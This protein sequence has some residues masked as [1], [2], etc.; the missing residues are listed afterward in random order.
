[1]IQR[2]L[3]ERVKNLLVSPQ[4]EWE[5]INTED[6]STRDLYLRYILILAAIPPFANFLGSWL[7]GFSH[8][9]GN[10]VHVAFLG[11]LYRALAQYVLTLPALYLV[12]F[13]VSYLAPHFDGV[14][15]DR[16]ALTLVAYSATPACL[17]AAFGLIPGLRWLDFIGLY[18]I[19]LFSVGLTPMTRVPKEN[20]DIF[21]MVCLVLAIAMGVLHGW[22]VHLIAPVDLL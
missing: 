6:L 14:S 13:V 22:I 9:T 15:D 3:F 2:R 21:T 7:F 8:G 20:A 1:M 16:R 4:T 11:G 17:A 10:W 18:G 12:A 19:Y 5:A